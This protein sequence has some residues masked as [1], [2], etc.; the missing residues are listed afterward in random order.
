MVLPNGRTNNIDKRYISTVKG[1]PK[2]V[3]RPLRPEGPRPMYRSAGGLDKSAPEIPGTLQ[4]I[5][6]PDQQ[7]WKIP[8]ARLSRH[9]DTLKYMMAADETITEIRLP[10]ISPHAFADFDLY[11]K[12]NIY[13]P[14]TNV[15]GYRSLRAHADACL[16]GAKLEADDY[17]EAGMRKLYSLFKPLA[18]SRRSDAKQSFIRA[19]D[20]AYICANTTT[21][22]L[23]RTVIT[24]PSPAASNVASPAQDM[25]MSEDTPPD[26]PPPL[27]RRG[28]YYSQAFGATD[29][30][31]S[32]FFD[33]LASHWTQHDAVY[34]GA[35]DS[36]R[37][38][39][40]NR[41][42][43]PGDSTTWRELCDAYPDFSAHMASTRGKNN[44]HRGSLLRPVGVYLNPVEPVDPEQEKEEGFRD[45]DSMGSS[46]T[47]VQTEDVDAIKEDAAEDEEETEME[48]AEAT[49]HP[50]LTI[51]LTGLRRTPSQRNL[52]TSEEA[53]GSLGK[54]S[55]EHGTGEENAGQDELPSDGNREDEEMTVGMDAGIEEEEGEG[56]EGEEETFAG[57]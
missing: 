8:K 35:Q 5:V 17:W 47:M 28:V 36:P 49:P 15:A 31:R 12:S 41:N 20:I 43:V 44:P 24:G 3:T 4:V 9:S 56:E 30:L 10:T 16:L 52:K 39:G 53:L 23:R 51:K 14:N 27:P 42:D 45:G 11:M 19:S 6:G 18:Q 40:F 38:G 50:K 2:S 37:G 33:A 48:T 7:T 22:S 57:C 32:L 34:I 21:E 26:S 29:G 25:A 46:D 1:T 55:E 54:E 13:S